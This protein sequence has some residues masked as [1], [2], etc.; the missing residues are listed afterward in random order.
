V[1]TVEFSGSEN[2]FSKSFRQCA[3][4][5]VTILCIIFVVAVAAGIVS[6]AGAGTPGNNS[7]A[8]TAEQGTHTIM[9][10]TKAQLDA[11][12]IA[13]DT[14]PKYSAPRGLM[15]T[16]SLP[17]SVNLLPYL[18][19]IPAERDQGQCG[20]CW[21]WAPTGAL[22]IEHNVN[23]RVRDRLSVQY[24]DSK[25]Q[26]T[27]GTS[28]C[29]GGYMENFTSFYNTDK[30]PIP[31]T[32]TNASYGDY[33]PLPNGSSTVPLSF[34]AT[35]PSYPLN[36]LTNSTVSTYGVGNATAI[37]NIRSALDSHH[38]VLYFFQMPLVGWTDFITF[39]DGPDSSLFDTSLYGGQETYGGHA[40]LIVGYDTTDP[41]NPYWVVVNSWGAP[42]NRPAGTY[43]LRMDMNYD[44]VVHETGSTYQQNQFEVLTTDFS[45]TPVVPAVSS[46]SPGTGPVTGGTPV[47]ITGIGFTGA[48]NVSFGGTPALSFTSVT[49]AEDSQIVAIAPAGTAGTVHVT[50]TNPSGT[51]AQSPGDL[52]TYPAAPAPVPVPG[53]NSGNG[54]SGTPANPAAVATALLAST[55]VV[56]TTPQQTP[57]TV[58]VNVG[59]S[60]HVS[61]VTVTGTDVGNLIVTSSPVSGPGTDVPL[62]PGIVMEYLDL[63]P[64]R[65]STI[66]GAE[67]SFTVPQSWMDEHH[68]TYQDIVLDHNAGNG[69]QALPTNFVRSM[70][71]TSW[72]EA[73]SPG[74]SRFA[75][76]GEAGHSAGLPVTTPAPSAQT[77]GDIAK[78]PVAATTA[79]ATPA[80][81]SV[82]IVAQTTIV[83]AAPQPATGLPVVSLGLAGAGCLV[84]I[85][86]VFIGRRWWIRRQ[87]PALFMK[88]D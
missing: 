2:T 5:A 33:R 43:R 75:I 23:Y 64:A 13:I 60:S 4:R 71:G 50:V 34:I 73:T 30:S 61:R 67:I 36:T 82:P 48:T 22:E 55:T 79:R 62:P 27:T 39:W 52:Y 45:G 70:S 38:P 66:T 40:V 8:I 68:F 19:Y 80:G 84:L 49:A 58:T 65:Y 35:S 76:V 53:D 85:G 37:A 7:A 83:P 9:H 47:T 51:S 24:M 15:R 20:N 42:G 6:P 86:S 29:F 74:F 21:V 32:N 3:N 46:I 87:N 78:S 10:L 44:A 31:W 69:W 81:T 57:G 14:A 77:F 11:Q 28:A 59:G 26:Y 54:Y 18:P 16:S 88:D 12:Q 41:A 25:Y 63:T 17:T 1:P 72:F 56:T